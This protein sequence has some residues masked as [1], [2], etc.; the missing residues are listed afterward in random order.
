M[1]A[2]LN[3]CHLIISPHGLG[4]S[5]VWLYSSNSG[6]EDRRDKLNISVPNTEESGC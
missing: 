1:T 2:Q 6:T 4:C 3:S 5:D